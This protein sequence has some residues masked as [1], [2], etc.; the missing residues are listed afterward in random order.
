MRYDQYPVVGKSKS[1]FAKTNSFFSDPKN[2][3]PHAGPVII[4]AIFTTAFVSSVNHVISGADGAK[5]EKTANFI[6]MMV[7]SEMPSEGV[8]SHVRTYSSGRAEIRMQ[9]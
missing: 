4:L 6:E 5:L 1:W 3:D 2:L 7:I 8:V 9:R